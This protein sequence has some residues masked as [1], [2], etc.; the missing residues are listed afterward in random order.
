MEGGNLEIAAEQAAQQLLFK[1]SG[2]VN[3]EPQV[4]E[5]VNDAHCPAVKGNV[6][7]GALRSSPQEGPR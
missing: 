7:N 3:L 2:I 4:C 1:D 5:R 6:G